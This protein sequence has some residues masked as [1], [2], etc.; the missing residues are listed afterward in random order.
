VSNVV[1]NGKHNSH[2]DDDSD[3]AWEEDQ[4]H[5][6]SSDI[7]SEEK[8]DQ[9]LEISTAPYTLEINLPMT[10]VGVETAD[11]KIVLQAIREISAHLISHALPTLEGWREVYIYV[12]IRVCIRVCMH[13]C[14][15][16]CT[17]V[18]KYT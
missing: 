15:Y 16:M 5:K 18:Y 10:A 17:Y 2:S 4:S 14:V 12:Y 3:V 8:E 6:D 13:V 9:R 11:N 1:K 7:G